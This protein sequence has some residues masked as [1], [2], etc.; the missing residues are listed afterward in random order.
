MFL[1]AHMS[2]SGGL[3]KAVE[4]IEKIDGTAL[5][6]FSRNQRQWKIKPL[7]EK[8]ICTFRDARKKW[9]GY[10][11]A[12]H[13]SYLINMASPDDGKRLKSAKSFS[14]EISRTGALGIEYLV[15]HPGS[16]LG[17]GSEEG[18]KTYVE[19]LDQAIRESEFSDVTVL[20]ETTAGQGTNLGSSFEELAAIIEKSSYPERL[21]ICF[22]TC[23]V[24][25]AGYDFRTEET[26]RKLF[27]H[28]DSLIGLERIK[29]FHL[30][31]SLNPLGSRKDRH[32]HIGSGE[33][34]ENAFRLIMR[35]ERFS[36]VPKILETPKGK[37][38]D[39]LE[40]DLRNLALLKKLSGQS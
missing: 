36:G 1:G 6:I 3:E 13:D 4:S 32:T 16:H 10:P 37:S 24:F 2:I 40:D 33:I 29:F 38:G 12:V 8:E 27:E 9:G 15:T 11:V 22:D 7:E 34:G 5:Q 20:L 31:D 39:G 35:D 19:T 21:G 26:Y 28:I 25:A 30:N 23:H 17:R 18:I 14:A